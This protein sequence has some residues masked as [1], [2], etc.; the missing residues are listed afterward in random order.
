L[1]LPTDTHPLA[2]ARAKPVH[3][4]DQ[5]EAPAEPSAA[6]TEKPQEP[7]QSAEPQETD[8]PSGPFTL[9]LSG[10]LTCFGGMLYTGW[11]AWDYRRR[12]RVLLERMIGTGPQPELGPGEGGPTAGPPLGDE[13]GP[14]GL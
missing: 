10:F 7:S 12:Y 6:E 5:Q 13:P 1:P 8:K 11:L 9:V 14:S 2:G 4:T 3:F